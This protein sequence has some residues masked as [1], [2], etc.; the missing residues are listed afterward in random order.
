MGNALGGSNIATTN[1]GVFT[2]NSPTTGS[3]DDNKSISDDKNVTSNKDYDYDDDDVSAITTPSDIYNDVDVTQGS[4]NVRTTTNDGWTVTR[5]ILL[6]PKQKQEQ[7][8]RTTKWKW[9]KLWNIKNNKRMN[10]KK[11]TSSKTTQKKITSVKGG[12][13]CGGVDLNMIQ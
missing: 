1:R 2:F 12:C 8:K 11:G 3:S 7:E 13:I 9:S 10:K 5:Q 6:Q 4:S